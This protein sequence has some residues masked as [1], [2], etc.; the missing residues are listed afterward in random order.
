MKTANAIKKLEKAGFKVVS[1]YRGFYY[2]YSPS[3]TQ[4]IDFFDH[5]DG[6]I[7]CGFKVKGV[8][9]KNGVWCENLMQA[10]LLAS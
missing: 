4:V 1:S 9:D 5:D 8:K 7:L 3:N 10:I 6:K 2:A